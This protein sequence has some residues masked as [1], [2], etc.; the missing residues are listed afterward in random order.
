MIISTSYHQTHLG[1]LILGSFENELVLCDWRYRKMRKQI[2]QRIRDGLK[3]DFHEGMTGL[4]E[5]CINELDEYLAGS[6]TEFTVPFRTVGSA[7]QQRVWEELCTIP[8]GQTETYLGL[9]QR[10]GNT[11]AI[12]AVAAANGANALSIIVPCHRI[13]GTKGELTGYAGGIKTKQKLL[14]MENPQPTLF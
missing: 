3:A 11:L 8:Y 12:R 6:R 4:I 1:E 7:F 13:V 9:S 2:D 14:E 10:L 5:Q